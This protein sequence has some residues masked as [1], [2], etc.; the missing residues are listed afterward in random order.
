MKLNKYSIGIGDRFGQEGIAQLRGL[1]MAAEQ[2]VH[3]TPVWNKSNREHIIIGSTPDDTRREAD[4]AVNALGWR[5]PYLVDADH[6]SFS[7]VG[8]FLASSDFFT[9]DVADFI[10]HPP[11]ADAA[12]TFLRA[13]ERFRGDLVVPG[14]PEPV[15]VDQTLLE[16]V[17]RKYLGAV[18]AAGTVY[19]EIARQRGS[20]TFVTEIS[21]D[22]ADEPQSPAELLFILAAISREG[23]PVQTIAP[24]FT[25]AFL[26]G[27]DYVGDIATFAREFEQDVAVLAFAVNSFN[28]SSD[29]KLSVHSGSDKFSLYPVIHRVLRQSGAGLHL[30]T[31]G[32][33]WLE[34]LIGLAEAEGEGLRAARHIFAE[35]WRRFDELCQPYRSVISID[36]SRLPDVQEVESW[37]GAHFAAV[38]RHDQTHELFNRDFRQLLH[39]G[40]KV[41]AEMG[42][43]F[44]VLLQEHRSVIEKNVIENLYR[45]HLVPL[46]LGDDHNQTRT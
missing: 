41:A 2:G 30:K 40:Y 31:A 22:E 28:L 11:P 46:Y 19:R 36:R 7:T 24:K 10:G 32:T 42:P 21:F 39:V 20:D 16:G 35:S 33:T 38:L 37:T 18:I 3:I 8:R 15:C 34:E 4:H 45:R 5:A 29:L 23:I 12:S 9:I 25:G 43:R 27:I 17:V 6:I 44:A 26:K 1:Q 13:M 14:I